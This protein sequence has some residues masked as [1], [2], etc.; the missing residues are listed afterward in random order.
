MGV[1][2]VSKDAPVIL[3]NG[4]SKSYLM[5]G[6]RCGYICLNSN[7]K[8]L[9]SLRANIPKLARVRIASN[10]PVQIGS[11]AGFTWPARPH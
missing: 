3:L 4:F 10:L 11:S 5:T 7:S 1:G 2:S 9:E 8:R 6:W